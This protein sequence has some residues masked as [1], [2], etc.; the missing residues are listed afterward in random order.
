MRAWLSSMIH[1]SVLQDVYVTHNVNNMHQYVYCILAL[2]TLLYR[3][4]KERSVL[5][6]L[7]DMQ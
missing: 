4:G 3:N 2:Y 5:S 7:M 1:C 6:L